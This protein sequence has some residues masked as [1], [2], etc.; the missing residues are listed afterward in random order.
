[1]YAVN[2]LPRDLDPTTIDFT[3][4]ANVFDDDGR[5]AD[6]C[7]QAGMDVD[8]VVMVVDDSVQ[9]LSAVFGNVNGDCYGGDYNIIATATDGTTTVTLTTPFSVKGGPVADV[10]DVIPD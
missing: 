5:D 4:R 3:I 6:R 2:W 1:M 9:Q 10:V 7:E 8:L